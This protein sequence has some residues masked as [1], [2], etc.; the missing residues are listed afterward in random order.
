MMKHLRAKI[1]RLI[2]AVILSMA[3]IW[4]G[5]RPETAPP[6]ISTPPVTAEMPD[7][8]TG[9]LL[10]VGYTTEV[11]GQGLQGPTQM[12]PGPAGEL[13]LAQLAGGENAGQGQVV[14]LSL[15]T[16]AQRVL[17]TDLFK[18]TGIAIL[19]DA[20]WIAAGRD[21]LRAPLNDA[22]AVGPVETILK[23]LPFNGR[24]NGAL[25]VSPAGRLLFETSGQR[26]GQQAVAGSATLW[27][28]DPAN[29]DSPRPIAIGLKNAYAHTFDAAGRL[30]IT[31][32]SDDPVNGE[33]PPDELNLVVEGAN[34]GWPACFGR[35]QPAFNYGGTAES[36]QATRPPVALFPPHTTPTSLVV[37][38]WEENT[39]LVALWGPPERA[40]V[41]VSLT[42]TGDNAVG[43]V[44]PFITGLQNPQHL[45]VWPDGSLLVSDS[46]AGVIYRVRPSPE[47]NSK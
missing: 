24:S 17:L 11:V 6:F 28:L 19:A 26:R 23:E 8:V 43:Q 32:V 4:A 25:T 22:G 1:A 2:S 18:P 3:A 20:L 21:L 30:W 36:C 35:Q 13:W 15:A 33:A 29:P 5:C 46:S 31:E 44:E 16:G 41:R 47:Q 39:L 38:P 45:L 42:L 9:L 10:P 37:S 12:I 27:E 14:V 34:F 40:V 7:Q